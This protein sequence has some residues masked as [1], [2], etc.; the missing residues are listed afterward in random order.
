[1]LLDLTTTRL[2]CQLRLFFS[3]SSLKDRWERWAHIRGYDIVLRAPQVKPGLRAVGQRDPFE[4]GDDWRLDGLVSLLVTFL[5]HKHPPETNMSKS[6]LSQSWICTVPL[7]WRWS[8]LFAT[9]GSQLT[10]H[11]TVTEGS[12]ANVPLAPLLEYF[13]HRL[14]VHWERGLMNNTEISFRF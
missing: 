13:A 6:D 7:L 1:M 14:A 12:H 5:H 10:G 11:W 8:S 2:F 9:V 4:L 3:M